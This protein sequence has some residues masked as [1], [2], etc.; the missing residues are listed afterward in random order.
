MSMSTLAMD[1]NAVAQQQRSATKAKQSRP[2]LPARICKSYTLYSA[3]I[4]IH[5]PVVETIP[6]LPIRRMISTS[7]STSSLPH[8]HRALPW[9]IHLSRTSARI[10]SRL[11]GTSLS[12]RFQ[13]RLLRLASKCVRASLRQ[14]MSRLQRSRRRA[15]QLPTESPP[16]FV[17]LAEPAQL[18]NVL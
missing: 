2:L 8:R 18:R 7:S 10:N 5:T 14:K 3:M 11:P 15:R 16:A 13:V 4:L 9:S 17:A 1:L 12:S 6:N